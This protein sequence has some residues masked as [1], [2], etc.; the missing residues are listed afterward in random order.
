MNVLHSRRKRER[1]KVEI[2]VLNEHVDELRV[3]REYLINEKN[4]L[5]GLLQA[6]KSQ[7]EMIE[8]GAMEYP[9]TPSQVRHPQIGAA[10]LNGSQAHGTPK[11][12]VRRLV[13][14]PDAPPTIQS[15]STPYPGQ[16]LGPSTEQMQQQEEQQQQ[17]QQHYLFP[18][19]NPQPGSLM[20][21]PH[22]HMNQGLRQPQE[23][24]YVQVQGAQ[25]QYAGD[26]SATFH[27]AVPTPAPVAVG[28]Q[29]WQPQVL[30]AAPPQ[31]QHQQPQF[32]VQM[33]PY[34]PVGYVVAPSVVMSNSGPPHVG[35]G[36]SDS[37]G[38][39]YWVVGGGAPGDQSQL[40]SPPPM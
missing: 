10:G 25:P 1:E 3:A 5:H 16:V 34:Q 21:F 37:S 12:S 19:G 4:R 40:G 38:R 14:R 18:V 29:H 28:S 9:S 6:A 26:H 24:H 39:G 2:G 11:P 8:R 31:Q 32:V 36:L 30:A 7:V 33:Q 35:G 23:P 20:M 27:Y 13:E 15:N 22:T 17:Q